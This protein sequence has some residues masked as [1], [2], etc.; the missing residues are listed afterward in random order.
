MHAYR[1]ANMSPDPRRK[2]TDSGNFH[3]YVHTY[4]HTHID[5]HT[6]KHMHACIQNREYEP[7]PKKKIHRLRK[8]S[9]EK[10]IDAN[11]QDAMGP[12]RDLWDIAGML[13]TYTI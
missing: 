1:T 7:R 2:F 12:E 13:Y 4:K 9:T 11:E 10:F 6:H 8:I 5:T 3:T